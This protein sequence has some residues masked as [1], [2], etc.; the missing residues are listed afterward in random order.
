MQDDAARPEAATALLE[1]YH[2]AVQTGLTPAHRALVLQ[3]RLV[4]C[5]QTLIICL[6]DFQYHFILD[7]RLLLQAH[8]HRPLLKLLQGNGPFDRLPHPQSA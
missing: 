1:V 5:C 8:G 2:T 3:T 4:S 7:C 6:A